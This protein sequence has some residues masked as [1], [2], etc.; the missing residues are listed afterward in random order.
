MVRALD[1]AVLEVA[2]RLDLRPMELYALLLLRAGG[3]LT[4][5][6]LA[7]QLA[8][9]PSQA[10]QLALRLCG[11]GMAE[12]GTPSGRT[13]LTPLGAAVADSAERDLRSAMAERISRIDDTSLIQ[14]REILADL[15]LPV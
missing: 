14:G 12:R 1:R 8:A 3:R 11:R 6:V 4:T 5:A 10:K 2:R 13:E 9:S 15:T 7:E